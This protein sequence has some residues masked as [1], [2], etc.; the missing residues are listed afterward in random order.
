MKPSQR[1]ALAAL[2]LSACGAPTTLDGDTQ[3]LLSG[4][5]WPQWGQNAQHAGNL[6]VVGQALNRMYLDYVYDPLLQDE[7][8]NEFG[9][10][11]VHYMTPLTEGTD[12]Y[13]ETKGGTF[14]PNTFS[15]ETWGVTKFSWVGGNLVQQWTTVTDWVAPG[16]IN[17]FWEPVFHAALANGYLYA[18]GGH[19]SVLKID[20]G[21]GAIVG[22]LQANDDFAPNYYTV[23]PVVTDAQGNLYFN[24]VK[25]AGTR[26]PHQNDRG[27]HHHRG[28]DPGKAATS[29]TDFYAADIAG[30]W[31]EKAGPDDRVTK[32]S[33]RKIMPLAPAPNDTC[34]GSFDPSNP[35]E[36]LPWPPSPTAVPSTTFACGSVR[37]PVSTAPAVG[38]D[39]TIYVAGVAHFEERYSYLSAVNPDFTVKWSA[40]LRNRFTDGC[41]VPIAQGGVL[42]ANGAPGGCRLGANYAVD[43]TTNRPGDGMA[44]DSSSASPTVAPDGSVFYGAYTRVPYYQGHLMH[45]DANGNYLGSYPFGWDTTAAVYSHGHSY[46]VVT[47]DN[48]YGDSGSYCDDE[49]YC[50]AERTPAIAPGFAEQ[51]GITQLSP[52]LQI[53]WSFLATN[54]QSCARDPSGAVNCVTDHPNSFEWCV[55]APAIDANGTVYVNSEDGWLYSIGQG[56]VLNARTFQ[57][58]AIGA[59]YTPASLGS[60]GKVYTQ[61][62]GHL[63]VIGN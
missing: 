16:S 31:L 49:N 35:A 52:S 25:T 11:L 60:D 57:Q 39:G 58:Q 13:M 63:F 61:N 15:S 6:P 8:A 2:A 22:R 29:T 33:Y 5:S 3:A 34:T 36:A 30:A 12:V 41:G 26:G 21:S 14:D 44:D 32:V 55:N 48:H 10:L 20:K 46:S 40:T 50:P 1:I 37:P 18:P 24:V 7:L 56:A 42:P 54:Q 43:P 51:Y 23:S 19:G 28:W 53:E 59:A 45:F 9:D 27:S 4:P 62:S 17:D 38:P 47:K